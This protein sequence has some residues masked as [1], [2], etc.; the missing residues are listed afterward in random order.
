MY[1]YICNMYNISYPYIDVFFWYR[2]VK[3]CQRDCF[4]SIYIKFIALVEIK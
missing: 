4:M 2:H 3:V 1:F